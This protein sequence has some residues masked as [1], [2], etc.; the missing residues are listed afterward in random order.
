[1]NQFRERKMKMKLGEHETNISMGDASMLPMPRMARRISM[2]G[3]IDTPSAQAASKRLFLF[4]DS[5]VPHFCRG[6]RESM[7]GKLARR[8]GSNQLDKIIRATDNSS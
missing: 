6:D 5:L 1:M 4:V 3:M 8:N 7:K 2:N